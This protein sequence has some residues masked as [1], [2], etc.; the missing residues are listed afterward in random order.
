MVEEKDIRDVNEL[1]YENL[2]YYRICEVLYV[3][4]KL[5]KYTTFTNMCRN[6]KDLI[7]TTKTPLRGELRKLI[8][9]TINNV[10]TVYGFTRQET[11][12]YIIK[13]FADNKWETYQDL[14]KI[15]YTK[16]RTS[17]Q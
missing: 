8:N 14:V 17:F 15:F 4:M 6:I 5:T 10:Q 2:I 11:I 12:E 13:F 1:R 9:K 7:V 3:E 16:T